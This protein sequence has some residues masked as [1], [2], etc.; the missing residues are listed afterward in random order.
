[1]DGFAASGARHEDGKQGQEHNSQQLDTLHQSD[2]CREGHQGIR[3]QISRAFTGFEKHQRGPDGS[4]GHNDK[5]RYLCMKQAIL[6]I[7]NSGFAHPEHLA[8]PR[9]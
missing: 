9:Q 3:W 4:Q 1:M 2:F 5:Q 6:G 7:K 8:Q